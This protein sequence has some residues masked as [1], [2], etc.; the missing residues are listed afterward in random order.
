MLPAQTSKA[1]ASQ[2]Q[3]AALPR[4]QR[5]CFPATGLPVDFSTTCATNC[6]ES[7]A[8]NHLHLC[9]PG[10]EIRALGAVMRGS[11]SEEQR[12]RCTGSMRRYKIKWDKTRGR[13]WTPTV[14]VW[15]CTEC[16]NKVLRFPAVF[17]TGVLGGGGGGGPGDRIRSANGSISSFGARANESESPGKAV[18]SPDKGGLEKRDH[19][20][21]EIA[22]SPRNLRS[23][24]S[25]RSRAPRPFLERASDIADEL[26]VDHPTHKHAHNGY[27]PRPIC[28]CALDGNSTSADTDSAHSPLYTPADTQSHISAPRA[29]PR[30]KTRV[31]QSGRA[32]TVGSFTRYAAHDTCTHI[33]ALAVNEHKS[34]LLERT[35]GKDALPQV[36]S[37]L[38]ALAPARSARITLPA[39][40]LHHL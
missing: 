20:S 33:S 28:A 9:G 16:T 38:P 10:R 40:R 14:C 25:S 36:A 7:A 32:L 29:S 35:Q 31:P 6:R 37:C 24:A 18:S 39:P 13:G 15:R 12:K 17:P 3:T 11:V 8:S 27:H 1:A 34:P 23:E 4:V 22:F 5:C 21:N 26:C 19:S 2:I 30:P